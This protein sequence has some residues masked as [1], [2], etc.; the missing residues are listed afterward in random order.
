MSVYSDIELEYFVKNLVDA[1]D[2]IEALSEENE[3]TSHFDIDVTRSPIF[4]GYTEVARKGID[5]IL[6]TIYT[7]QELRN[8][9]KEE[10]M[11]KLDAYSTSQLTSIY[12]TVLT[13]IEQHKDLIEMLSEEDGTSFKKDTELYISRQESYLKLI[14][15]VIKKRNSETPAPE[16]DPGNTDNTNT[17]NGNS[18]NNNAGNDNTGETSNNDDTGSTSDDTGSNT[19]DNNNDTENSNTDDT[20]NEN[21]DD[22]DTTNDNTGEDNN[23]EVPSSGLGMGLG[24]GNSFASNYGMTYTDPDSE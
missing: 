22:P 17:D 16:N 24:M 3:D 12:Y 10:M 20:P 8:T 2:S 15:D 13:D 7:E 5:R 11:K 23:T 14:T 21:G 4:F 6:N 1:L 19:E 9:L 18:E